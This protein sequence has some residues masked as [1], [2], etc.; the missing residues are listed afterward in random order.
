MTDGNMRRIAG[1]SGVIRLGFS[2]DDQAWSKGRAEWM[3]RGVKRLPK[4]VVPVLTLFVSYRDLVKCRAVRLP[5]SGRIVLHKRRSRIWRMHER[6]VIYTRRPPLSRWS[7]PAS[8]GGLVVN[9]GNFTN[10]GL[11]I[12]IPLI[13]VG[14]QHI[15]LESKIRRVFKNMDNTTIIWNCTET[16][17]CG[18]PANSTIIGYIDVSKTIRSVKRLLYYFKVGL[19]SR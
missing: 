13:A 14:L 5:R 18:R 2:R 7:T 6:S 9:D 11:L 1:W 19:L 3:R 10:V 15:K 8:L 16:S 4:A 17:V 12:R